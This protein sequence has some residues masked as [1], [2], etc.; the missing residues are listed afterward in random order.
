VGEKGPEIVTGPAQ[1]IGRR[2]T[3]ELM[4]QQAQPNQVNYTIVANDALS[5]KQMLSRDPEFL[6]NVTV[7]GS[8]RIPR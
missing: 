4:N 8:R 1:V 5:F 2:E 6:Y 7:A 3:A